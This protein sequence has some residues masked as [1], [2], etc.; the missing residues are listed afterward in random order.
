[1]SRF[2]WLFY[3]FALI[4]I[5]LVGGALYAYQYTASFIDSA[6]TAEGEVISLARSTSSGSSSSSGG[7][8][9]APVVAFTAANGE[10]YEFTSS[11]SSNPPSYRPGD[12]VR[13]Y[14][15]EQDP[16]DAEVDGFFSLWGGVL[17]LG[18]L[19]AV[20]S[21]FGFGLLLPGFLGGRSRARLLR[22]GT[23]VQARIQ[24]IERQRNIRVGGR[25]PWRI[26]AQWQNPRTSEIHLF[27]SDHIWFDPTDHIARDQVTV[28]IDPNK[29]KRHYMDTSFLPKLAE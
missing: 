6:L 15:L 11:A 27:S 3:L 10:R 25:N 29:P 2:R 14:Y 26:N 20:F 28:Y 1:M 18:I 4:G 7:S 5:G 8:T 21:A 22:A 12:L 13:V 24:G 16:Y 9:Y 23:P 19:G 17:I